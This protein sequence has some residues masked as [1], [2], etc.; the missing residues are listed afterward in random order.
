MMVAV[1]V[2]PPRP[3]VVAVVDSCTVKLPEASEL[4]AGVNF[5]PAA[6]SATVMKSPLLIT[7][8]P[9]FLKSVPPVMF[10][11]WKLV[12][13]AASAAIRGDDQSRGRLGIVGGRGVRHVRLLE[14]AIRGDP[15]DIRVLRAPCVVRLV[16][17]ERL[18]W[19]TAVGLANDVNIAVR[20]G[21]DSIS[22]LAAERHSPPQHGNG[23][24]VDAGRGIVLDPHIAVVVQRDAIGCAVEVRR[25][26]FVAVQIVF[27][28]ERAPRR[29]LDCRRRY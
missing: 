11:I 13:K 27:D 2:G 12:T 25:E 5:S 23:R 26:Q 19:M 3:A 9:S 24:V 17:V 14:R 20:I 29:R 18:K 6:P 1:A 15:H 28:E 8:V 4:V 22:E 7:V 10:V 16:R 21:G